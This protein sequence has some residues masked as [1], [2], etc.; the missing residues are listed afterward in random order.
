MS[1]SQVSARNK[2]PVRPFSLTT[3]LKTDHQG[4]DLTP[5]M[6]SMYKSIRDRAEATMPTSVAKGQR[7]VVIVKVLIQSDGRLAGPAFPK[8]I[9]RSGI[10][11]L[12]DHAMTATR[13]AAPFDRLPDSTPVPVE[14][15]VMFFYNLVPAESR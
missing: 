13:E 14:I 11:E 9:Y 3:D 6:R 12:D 5:F 7:G 8:I 15:D 10:K 2:P 1:I 4:I